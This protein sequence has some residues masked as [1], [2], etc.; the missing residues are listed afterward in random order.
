MPESDSAIGRKGQKHTGENQQRPP[1]PGQIQEEPARA[2]TVTPRVAGAPCQSPIART[3]CGPALV[4]AVGAE[5]EPVRIQT[6]S[7]GEAKFGNL[8]TV[9]LT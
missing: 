4:G 6:L 8:N 1:E 3:T 7:R 9:I 5:H 2:S